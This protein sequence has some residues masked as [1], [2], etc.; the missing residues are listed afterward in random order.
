MLFALLSRYMS[1][2]AFC[3]DTC[4]HIH[5]SRCFCEH[6]LLRKLPTTTMTLRGGV[7]GGGEALC[8]WSCRASLP[9]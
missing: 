6:M 7:D 2:E 5:A 3:L 8:R 1:R 4:K 9:L